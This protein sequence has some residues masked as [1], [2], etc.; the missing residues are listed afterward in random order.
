MRLNYSSMVN[1]SLLDFY[2]CWQENIREYKSEDA[3][4]KNLYLLIAFVLFV[5]VQ[6]NLYY[7]SKNLRIFF[8]H[9]RPCCQQIREIKLNLFLREFQI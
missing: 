2:S 7:Q 9:D 6:I 1:V 3:D 5:D 8:F 4:Y